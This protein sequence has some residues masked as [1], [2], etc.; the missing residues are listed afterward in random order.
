M[1]F[2]YSPFQQALEYNHLVKKY[3]ILQSPL[4]L[5]KVANDWTLGL[6][7]GSIELYTARKQNKTPNRNRGLLFCCGPDSTYSFRQLINNYSARKRL[8]HLRSVISISSELALPCSI[9][10]L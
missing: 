3:L 6:A 8:G 4:E 2:H 5:R 10:E 1:L 7:L 9:Q